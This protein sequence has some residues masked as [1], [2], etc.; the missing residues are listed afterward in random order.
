MVSRRVAPPLGARVLL[1]TRWRADLE[2]RFVDLRRDRGLPSWERGGAKF[3]H[4]IDTEPGRRIPIRDS[5]LRRRLVLPLEGT[6]TADQ[7]RPAQVG[8]EGGRRARTIG[9]YIRARSQQERRIRPSLAT[10]IQSEPGR[11]LGQRPAVLPDRTHVLAPRRFT[12]WLSP[13]HGFA[14]VGCARAISV[15]L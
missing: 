15:S 7:C 1:A 11:V 2:R 9:A 5:G 13:S 6:T 4:V 10:A 14:G 8:V 12:D 3:Y